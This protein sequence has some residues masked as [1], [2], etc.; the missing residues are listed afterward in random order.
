VFGLSLF[1]DWSARDIQAWEYQPLGPFLSK[2]FASTVSP[3]MVT[4]DALAPFRKPWTR[5]E[6]EPRPLPYLDS[7]PTA[8]GRLRA[9]LADGRGGL[10]LL[11]RGH[12]FLAGVQALQPVVE[13]APRDRRRIGA[14]EAGVLHHH[15]DRDLRVLGRRVRH[16]QRVVAMALVHLRGV[17]LLVLRDRDHLRGAG[18]AA[19]GVGRARKAAADVPSMFTPTSALRMTAR[20]SG[21]AVSWPTCSGATSATAAW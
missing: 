15:R 10:A 16:E 6:G 17:V 18:L 1:N 2:N 20:F 3:W 7:P 12:V 4:L 21:L 13:H 5:A 19:A 8:P 14:A 9:R 11:H